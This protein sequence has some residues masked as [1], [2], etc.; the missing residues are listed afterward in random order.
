MI[1]V[2]IYQI[3]DGRLCN[4]SRPW[5]SYPGY[6][7]RGVFRD[8][9]G[10]TKEVAKGPLP[11]GLYTCGRPQA[12]PRLGPAA[13]RLEPSVTTPMHGRSGFFIHGDNKRGDYSASE[14]CIVVSREVRDLFRP[15][16]RLIVVP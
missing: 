16:D 13:I 11:V 8:D 14:G 6:S 4:A 5:V 3:A 10:A 15:G 9:P 2:W 12:H 7:G 1:D